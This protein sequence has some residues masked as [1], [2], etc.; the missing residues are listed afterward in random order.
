MFTEIEEQIRSRSTEDAVAFLLTAGFPEEDVQ[1]HLNAIANAMVADDYTGLDF[2]PE[3]TKEAA[4]AAREKLAE[5]LATIKAYKHTYGGD[6]LAAAVNV[7]KQK[8]DFVPEEQPNLEANY[9]RPP[10][11]N[12]ERDYTNEEQERL[13]EVEAQNKENRLPTIAEAIAY[14]QELAD[15]QGGV[16]EGAAQEVRDA[17]R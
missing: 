4:M 15:K 7:L 1:P 9:Q 5:D 16:D 3:A 8:P 10:I 6:S 13:K 2:L 12:P 14:Q 17:A 11:Q